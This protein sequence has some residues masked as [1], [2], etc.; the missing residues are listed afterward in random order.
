[1]PNTS[2]NWIEHFIQLDPLTWP[3]SRPRL[4]ADVREYGLC[5]LITCPTL[6]FPQLHQFGNNGLLC[7]PPVTLYL[8]RLGR[9]WTDQWSLIS[10]LSFS[11]FVSPRALRRLA[12]YLAPRNAFLVA[13]SFARPPSSCVSFQYLPSRVSAPIRYG[14]YCGW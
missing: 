8:S 9:W 10:L 6:A 2:L 5:W 13:G 12:D 3:L 7:S 11:L 4:A 1:M 14:W